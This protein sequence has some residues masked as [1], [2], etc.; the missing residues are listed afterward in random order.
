MKIKTFSQFQEL[1]KNTG[2]SR[3]GIVESIQKNERPE[4][5]HIICLLNAR[6]SL[7]NIDMKNEKYVLSSDDGKKIYLDLD[8]EIN[9]LSKDI[10]FLQ[11]NEK[12]FYRYLETFYK[13]FEADV[14][15]VSKELTHL[16]FRNFITDRDGTV[17]NYCGRYSTSIQP[18]Y[19]GVFLSRFAATRATN[20]VILTSAPLE[21][22]GL[23]DLSV[24]AQGAYIY[25]G[26][27]GRELMNAAGRV[28]RFPINE[29]QQQ[30]I[31]K[32]NEKL[33]ELV[34]QAEYEIFSKIG[35][36][37][38]F[39]FGQTT[40][41]R[42][43]I[44]NNI[45]ENDSF[46]FKQLIEDTVKEIDPDNTIFRIEDTGKDL[47]IILTVDSGQKGRKDF[48]K[49]DGVR[50]I[51]EKL[52]L[53]LEQGNILVCGDTGSDLPM[54]ETAMKQNSNTYSVFVTTNDELKNQVSTICPNA[55]FVDMPDALVGILNNL[56]KTK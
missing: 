45:P 9:E 2:I 18:A 25:A 27:K 40:I 13:G 44:Y 41:A 38:Q 53:G 37:L 3:Q 23:V 46:H 15:R 32:L 34:K 30:R 52:G 1:L 17:N 31:A 51:D 8:Y 55:F 35:S 21:D 22:F 11:Q 10:Y 56:A 39:K 6:A 33:G 36:G 47:E 28:F 20:A 42:Q 50:F 49:G 29:H 14:N 4:E 5:K 43:D 16:K 24:M 19:N 26:S 54:V 12:T 48:D 7:E